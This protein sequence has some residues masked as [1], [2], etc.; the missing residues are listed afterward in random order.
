MYRAG[1][2]PSEDPL[3]LEII[4]DFTYRLTFTE[5]FGDFMYYLA[6]KKYSAY[7][8][9]IKPSHFLKQYHIEYTSLEKMKP[10]LDKEQLG[11]DWWKLFAAK[12]VPHWRLTR[13]KAIGFPTLAPWHRVEGPP[14][15]IVMER[16]PY[17]FKVDA[18]GK[19]LP[20]IDRLE[21]AYVSDTQLANM[22]VV[23]GEFDFLR[24]DTGLNQM[25]LYKEYEAKGG[26][27][28]VLVDNTVTPSMLE[29]NYTF[30]DPA[31]REVVN[32][33]R[34]RE[35]L[36]YA[37]NRKEINDSVYYGLY[38]MPKSIPF[39]YNPDKAGQLLDE[40]VMNNRDAQG[41]RLGPGGKTFEFLFEVR[42]AA[43]DL[44]PTAELVT[45]HLKEVGIFVNMKTVTRALW[46]TR[47]SANEIKATLIWVNTET[48][49]YVW[50]D[51][52]PGA[53]RWGN[54]WRQWY[55]TGGDSGEEPPAWIKKLY[56]VH[57]R[58][59]QAPPMSQQRTAA[60]ADLR[61]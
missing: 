18:E 2:K 21:S 9:W 8:D 59:M 20:Y 29:I 6:R 34:F 7:T 60:I 35:A 15:L 23:D 16:N 33:R 13:K 38:G 25:P 17:Y 61:A 45:E 10:D 26:F 53:G 51:Y 49:P 11:E 57:E 43:P 3:K 31:W 27:R 55:N 32:D 14:E 46:G 19:Q 4:D 42:D 12:D 37:I 58:V 50:D 47:A 52:L 44:I 1:G 40:M 24:E 39:E 22:R 56:E 41:Y 5:A 36:N 30:A 48:R 54:P 28:A